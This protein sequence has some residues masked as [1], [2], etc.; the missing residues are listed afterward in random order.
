MRCARH[1]KTPIITLLK[2]LKDLDDIYIYQEKPT[3]FFIT[4]GVRV[5]LRAPQLIP[6]STEYPANLMN[7]Q[8]TAG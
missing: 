6:R 4:R 1:I 2:L 7:M 5:S 3:F 8:G